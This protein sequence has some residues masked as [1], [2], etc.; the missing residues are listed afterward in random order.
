[1]SAEHRVN[2]KN[3]VQDEKDAWDS[4][5]SAALNALIAKGA[6]GSSPAALA[7]DF[8]TML[9]DERRKVFPDNARPVNSESLSI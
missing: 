6:G 9:L 3:S 7:A 8:A 1:M 4:Y 5:A 2:S